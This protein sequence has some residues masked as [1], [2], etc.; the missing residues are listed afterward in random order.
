MVEWLNGSGNTRAGQ[1]GLAPQ[2]ATP[3][4]PKQIQHPARASVT[5]STTRQTMPEEQA[6]GRIPGDAV[7]EP[8]RKAVF[9]ASL[10][11][12]SPGKPYSKK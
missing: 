4:G 10:K 5:A 8:S 3:S 7:M 6:K 9:H 12:P 2:G 11:E 1:E